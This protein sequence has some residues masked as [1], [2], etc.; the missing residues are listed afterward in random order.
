MI[1]VRNLSK[2]FGN[3]VV[4]DDVSFR[5]NDANLIVILGPSGTGKSVLLKC[6]LG[7]IPA[8]AG[9]V[10]FDG[11][12]VQNLS[13]RDIY[14]IRKQVGFVFQSTALFDSMNVA[15]NIALPL[16]EHTSLSSREI[17]DH[18]SLPNSPNIRGVAAQHREVR[19]CAW[20]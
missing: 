19:L 14:E 20:I 12:S 16:R 6:M 8:D 7:L 5:V 2:S 18:R 10:L 3:L 9:E 1:E 4:L 15:D 11:R 17:H 13:D